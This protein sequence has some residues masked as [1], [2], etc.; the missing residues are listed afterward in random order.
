MLRYMPDIPLFNRAISFYLRNYFLFKE[1]FLLRFYRTK[2]RGH[3]A[4]KQN[5]L[6]SIY[7][8]TYNRGQILINRAINSVL[9]QT[10]KNYE[11]II[12]DDGSVD[13]TKNLVHQ[14][15]D[16]RI[17][18]ICVSRKKYRYPNK[19]IYHWLAGPVTAANAALTVCKGEWIARIDDD[20]EW[21]PTHLENLLR[22][23]NSNDFEFVS[24][25]IEII[26]NGVIRVVT[27]FDDPRDQTGI[28]A[29]QT[30]LYKSYLK[31][32]RYNINCW[33][34][35]YFRVNDTDVAQ[36]MYLAGVKIGYLHEV[37]AKIEPRPDESSIGSKAYLQNS[38]KYEK[39]YG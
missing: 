3:H 5:P 24:S 15:S 36:R 25:D 21:L 8:P 19:A 12:A 26:E 17:K 14:I 16:P 1:F 11:L 35:S 34:K 10:Y 2:W 32:F 39:F 20:D 23:A 31:F 18:Y 33:R 7:I 28:G 22:H 37:T 4:L 30:W 6:I 13:D 29:T 9:R 27:G 38:M